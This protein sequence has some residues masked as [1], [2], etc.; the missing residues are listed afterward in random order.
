MLFLAKLSA[1]PDTI[2]AN[3]ESKWAFEQDIETYAS[4]SGVG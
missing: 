3:G 2:Q 4:Y 1:F